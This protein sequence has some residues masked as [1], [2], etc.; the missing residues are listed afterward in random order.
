M[1]SDCFSA[2]GRYSVASETCLLLVLLPY[3]ATGEYMLQGNDMLLFVLR[4]LLLAWVLA[5]KF[6]TFIMQGNSLMRLWAWRL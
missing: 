2:S 6:S 5:V 3:S 4:S 1:H